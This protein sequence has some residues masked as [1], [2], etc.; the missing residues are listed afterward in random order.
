MKYNPLLDELMRFCFF[1]SG[2]ECIVALLGRSVYIDAM[3]TIIEMEL[4]K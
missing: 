4:I 1:Y 3:L 2:N